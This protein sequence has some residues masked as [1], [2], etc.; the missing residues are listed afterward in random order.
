MKTM[1]NVRL[2]THFNF[3]DDKTGRRV[4]GTK[5]YYDGE[6]VNT[7]DKKGIELLT[8][9]SDNYNSFDDFSTVPAVYE[10]DFNLVPGSKGTVK[11]QYVSAKLKQEKSA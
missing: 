1:A 3:E 8:I 2:V 5:V 10:L 6:S 4:E 11:M 9:T 7:S